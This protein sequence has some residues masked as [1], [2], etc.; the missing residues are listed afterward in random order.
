L[1]LSRTII[2]SHGG[3]LWVDKHYREGALF[4]FALPVAG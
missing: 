4:G 1:S 2:E 3:R